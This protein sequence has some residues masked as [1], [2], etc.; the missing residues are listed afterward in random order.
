MEPA[1]PLEREKY[2]RAPSNIR[3]MKGGL[4]HFTFHAMTFEEPDKPPRV[5]AK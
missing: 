4:P 3:R 1:N 2:A 5:L